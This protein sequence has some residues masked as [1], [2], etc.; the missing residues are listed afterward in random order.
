MST[1]DNKA[2]IQRVFEEVLNQGNMA[3]VDEVYSP[4]NVF[5][6][7]TGPV[8]GFEGLK[9]FVNMYRSAFPDIQFTIEDLIAEGDKIVT[10]Y[11]ARGTHRGDLQGIPPT[12]RQ[13]TVTGIIISRFANGKFVEG[14]L[15]FDA[16]GMLQQLGVIPAP[17]QA[18]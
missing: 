7:S 14:W 11:T 5:H 15:D 10:R 16:L 9:Q 8:H 1:E 6:T 12:G 2:A 3:V 4:D 17:G 18:S 13:V